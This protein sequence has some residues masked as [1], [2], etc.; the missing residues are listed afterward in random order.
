[1]NTKADLFVPGPPG[2]R[3]THPLGFKTADKWERASK[4]RSA[5]QLSLLGAWFCT[6][7]TLPRPFLSHPLDTVRSKNRMNVR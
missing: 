4:S 3:F 6:V 2:C 5:A 1:V 7:L